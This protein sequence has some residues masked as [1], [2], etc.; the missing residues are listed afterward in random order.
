MMEFGD[1]NKRRE[2]TI[3]DSTIF[4]TLHIY[5]SDRKSIF[6]TRAV[7]VERFFFSSLLHFDHH[8]GR[9][10]HR[11]KFLEQELAGVRNLYFG[12]LSLVATAFA[13]ERVIAQ[14]G[15]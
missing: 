11:H 10:A 8:S 4:S 5:L 15:D 1:E 12:D 9:D 2:K 3:N 6:I 14:V 13:L 7:A